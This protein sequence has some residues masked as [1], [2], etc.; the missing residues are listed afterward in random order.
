MAYNDCEGDVPKDRKQL[1]K[2]SEKALF[3]FYD[4]EAA[5]SDTV[6]ADIV[7]IAARTDPEV[8]KYAFQSLVHTSQKLEK[9]SMSHCVYA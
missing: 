6:T 3:I 1:N 4:C 5:G 8:G 7:E 9:F 2:M